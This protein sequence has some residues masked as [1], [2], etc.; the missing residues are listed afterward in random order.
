MNA[1]SRQGLVRLADIAQRVAYWN[2]DGL[3]GHNLQDHSRGGRIKFVAD[4]FGFQFHD[5]LTGDDWIA[6]PLQPA[7]NV[8]L[9]ARNPA[10]FRHNDCGDDGSPVDSNKRSLKGAGLNIAI[11]ERSQAALVDSAIGLLPIRLT[12]CFAVGLARRGFRNLRAK[13][14]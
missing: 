2:L 12:Q 14:H 7:H 6:F 10:R 4:L 11:G 5:R 3:T 8:R 13:F 9:G 1:H